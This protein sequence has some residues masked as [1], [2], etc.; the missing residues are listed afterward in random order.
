MYEEMWVTSIKITGFSG[1][2]KL[3]SKNINQEWK[4]VTKRQG[5]L[6]DLILFYIA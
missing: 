1:F 4:Y 3:S 6:T 2:Y 5:S